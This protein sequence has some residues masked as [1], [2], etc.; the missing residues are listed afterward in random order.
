MVVC[1]PPVPYIA[2]VRRREMDEW[3]GGDVLAMLPII[4]CSN[5]RA[6]RAD[7]GAE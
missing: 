6:R 1:S 7:G 4:F 5:Q 2:G 3:M